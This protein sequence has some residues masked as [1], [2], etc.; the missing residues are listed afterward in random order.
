ML[1]TCVAVELV[2]GIAEVDGLEVRRIVT[3]FEEIAVALALEVT[4][5]V[6]KLRCIEA[7]GFERDLEVVAERHG[8]AGVRI[9]RRGN[10]VDG[11]R[12]LAELDIEAVVMAFSPDTLEFDIVVAVAAIRIHQAVGIETCMDI[13]VLVDLSLRLETEDVLIDILLALRC[14]RLRVVTRARIR[15]LEYAVPLDLVGIALEI[16]HADAEVVQLIGKL[17]GELVDQGLVGSG[18][19]AL[20]HGLRDHLS[21]LI[22]RDVLVAAERRV[23]VAFDDAVSCELRYCIV[24]PVVCRDIRERIGSCKRRAC[25]ADNE[26][27]RECGYQS[28]LHIELPLKVIVSHRS[29]MSVHVSSYSPAMPSSCFIL[30]L[31]L[32]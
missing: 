21:H 5:H 15:V 29:F 20:G 8:S 25:S 18:D 22:A 2:L 23:A 19:I 4:C 16:C 31:F 12:Q 27:R 3:V 1:I 11:I 32:V 30:K 14:C 7:A 9:I 6:A 17:S 28:L 13:P 10:Q 26:C 24:C